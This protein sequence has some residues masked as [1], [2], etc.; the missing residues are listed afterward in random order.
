[1]FVT[2]TEQKSDQLLLNSKKNINKVHYG[3]DWFSTYYKK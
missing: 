3:M 2:K 1:M